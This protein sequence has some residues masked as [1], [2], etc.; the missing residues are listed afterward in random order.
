MQKMSRWPHLAC[1]PENFEDFA[2]VILVVR[3]QRLPAHSQ[4]LA[5]HSKLLQNIM[6]DSS[7]FSKDAP[8]VLDRQLEGFAASDLQ[9]FLNQVYLATV[10]RSV[11]DA[12]GLLRIADLF[13]AAKL[14]GKAIAYLEETSAQ[15]LFAS[16]S[17]ILQWLLLAERYNM[18]SFMRRCAVHAAIAYQEVSKDADFRN[19]GSSALRAV[20]QGLHQL[21]EV[22]PGF[23]SAQDR[24]RP[25]FGFDAASFA[26]AKPPSVAVSQ[27]HVSQTYMCKYSKLIPL[28]GDL[29][30]KVHQH[31]VGHCVS[32]DWN[33]GKQ[34]WQLMSNPNVVTKVLPEN[35]LEL[36]NLI[37]SLQLC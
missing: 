19:L 7:T 10:I 31:C 24:Q 23:L 27:L 33:L 17:T 14:V 11:A 5:S 20:M 4:Y 25:R 26:V 22:Y 32:W 30:A 37:G 6:R 15:D 9:T 3:E 21:T 16:S 18:T 1:C 8:L 2:D 29:N 28:P 12:Q 34:M 13:D 36:A 35:V